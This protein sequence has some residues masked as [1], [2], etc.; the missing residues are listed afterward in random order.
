[1][2]SASLINLALLIYKA[3]TAVKMVTVPTKVNAFVWT[4]GT[5]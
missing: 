4:V 5:G 2:T 3:P 1:M